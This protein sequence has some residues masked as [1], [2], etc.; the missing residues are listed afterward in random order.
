MT[1]TVMDRPVPARYALKQST[2]Q[3]ALGMD[4]TAIADGSP[5]IM[6][7][8]TVPY[9]Y[10]LFY[11]DPETA[12]RKE[13]KGTNELPTFPSDTLETATGSADVYGDDMESFWDEK[14]QWEMEMC[15]PFMS[16]SRPQRFEGPGFVV[17]KKCYRPVIR[18]PS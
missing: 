4:I 16:L 7:P 8:P 5:S 14:L 3:Q 12:E 18:F 6:E 10:R 9:I 11:I 15:S 13:Y 2:T 1:I 17:M